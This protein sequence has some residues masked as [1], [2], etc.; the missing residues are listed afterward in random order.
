MPTTRDLAVNGLS[1]R[2]TEHGSGQPVIMCHGFPGLGYTWRHQLQA[3]GDAGWHAV[4]P[5]MRGYGHTDRPIDVADYDAEHV[6]GD[7]IGLLDALGHERAVF[8]GHDFG[9]GAVWDIAMRHPDRVAAV[10]VLSVPFLGRPLTRPSDTFATMA[11]DHFLHLHYFQ[12]IGPADDELNSHPEQFLTSIYWALSGAF[13]YMDI[14]QHPSDGHGYLDVLPTAPPLPWDWL[15]EADLQRMLADFSV[16]GFSGGLN[17]YRAS[18]LR[19][20]Q[21][22][23]FAT[24]T[25]DVPA[26]FICGAN[27]TVLEMA[28]PDPIGQM[29]N[30]VTD[31]RAVEILP[32]AGHFVQLERPTEVNTAMIDFLSQLGQP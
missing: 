26:A 4:A 24:A 9:A 11:K 18:D 25:V 29:R 8:V 23:Q 1:M 31:L 20:E 27:D 6:A 5:D 12:Q 17:W 10:I 19:W 14:W 22:V 15:S 7:L 28:G 13:R 32:G 3:I 16:S 2:I 21:T 30:R